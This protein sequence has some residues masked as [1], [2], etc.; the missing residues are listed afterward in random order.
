MAR[1]ISMT[2]IMSKIIGMP[3]SANSNNTPPRRDFGYI[4]FGLVAY[5]A[6]LAI[7]FVPEGKSGA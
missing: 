7:V 2:E 6:L 3:A 1:E 4:Q 5:V